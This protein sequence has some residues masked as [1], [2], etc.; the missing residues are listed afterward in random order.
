ML[1]R[2]RKGNADVGK[3]INE[4]REKLKRKGCSELHKKQRW[5]TEEC[6]V[7]NVTPP[8]ER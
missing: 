5:L 1:R 8:E 2:R 4:T 7:G 3:D 6:Q